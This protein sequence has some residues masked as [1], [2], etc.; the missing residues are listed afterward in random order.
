MTDN[1][2]YADVHRMASVVAG[3]SLGTG[4]ADVDPVREENANRQSHS[5]C[6]EQE[7]TLHHASGS[8][9]AVVGDRA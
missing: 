7:K 5:E 4:R 1:C 2:R 8:L 3:L 9:R 6:G